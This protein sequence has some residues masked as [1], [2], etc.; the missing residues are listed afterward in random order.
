MFAGTLGGTQGFCFP[1]LLF[2]NVLDCVSSDFLCLFLMFM[3]D[4]SVTLLSSGKIDN[5]REHF[6]NQAS[7]I[8]ISFCLEVT[9]ALSLPHGK[10][11]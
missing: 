7:A 5:F 11:L 9:K 8:D 4:F 1:S 3:T 6:T 10:C 2:L